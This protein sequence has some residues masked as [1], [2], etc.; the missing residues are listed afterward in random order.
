[1]CLDAEARG[2]AEA[3]ARNL[4][5]MA[6]LRTP[7]VVVV[8]GEGGSG[9]ALGIAVGDRVL[10]LQ[11]A[12]YSVISP[13]GCASILWRDGKKA[14]EAAEA[15]KITS[16]ALLKLGV[17]DAVVPEVAGGAHTDPC[18]TIATVKSAVLSAMAPLMERPIKALV[19]QRYDKFAAMGR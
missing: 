1:M 9:G 2:Q 7:F 18:A 6:T 17:I 19:A 4:T 3:I 5:V 11:N 13:E 15:L 12:V 16:G 14:P 8:T 10:M